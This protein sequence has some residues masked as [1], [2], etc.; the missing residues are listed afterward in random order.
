[1]EVL[2]GTGAGQPGF[3]DNLAQPRGSQ[4]DRQVVADL[5]GQHV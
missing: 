5:A 2:A 3:D 1:M 4:Q